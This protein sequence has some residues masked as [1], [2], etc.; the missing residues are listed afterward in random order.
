MVEKKVTIGFPKMREE[1]NERRAFLPHFIQQISP[2][3]L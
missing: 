2:H 3:R 1:E